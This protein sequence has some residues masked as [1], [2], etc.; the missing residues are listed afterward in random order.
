[1]STDWEKI[2]KSKREERVRLAG[3]PIE[4][5][6]RILDQIRDRAAAIKAPKKVTHKKDQAE[7]EK[8]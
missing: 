8:G 3:L 4:E 6:F 7:R 2:E 5:K 1:M